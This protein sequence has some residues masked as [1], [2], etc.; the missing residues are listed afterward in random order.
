QPGDHRLKIAA[1]AASWAFFAASSALTRSISC[2]RDAMRWSSSATERLSR[3]SPIVMPLGA[4]GF[5]SSQ[6]MTFSRSG[7]MATAAWRLRLGLP[8]A[9]RC[10]EPTS[11]DPLARE[12]LGGDRLVDGGRPNHL[13]FPALGAAGEWK[14]RFPP[15]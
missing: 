4:L 5:R 15:P 3:L 6:S 1:A 10:D 2:S 12:R 13:F 9:L 7:P 8:M 14:C 11:G